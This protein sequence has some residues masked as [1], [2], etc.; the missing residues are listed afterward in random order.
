L[1]SST[2]RSRALFKAGFTLVELMVVVM[3]VSILCVLAVPSLS[4][5]GYE[6][7]AYT[8]AANV[9][10]LVREARTR[11][12]GRGA[13]ELLVMSASS[14]ANTASFTLYEAVTATGAGGADAGAT[15]PSSTCNPPTIWPGGSGTVTASFVDG[16][17]IAPTSS[18]NPTIE[19]QGNI[20][21]RVNDPNSGSS[22]GANS[23]YL[24]FT[25]AGRTWYYD[26]A[27]TPP[28]TFTQSLASAGG[29]GAIT[30]DVTI[31]AFPTSTTGATSSTNLIRTV[32]I[33]PSGNTRVTSQ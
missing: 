16:F 23:L 33:P 15:I 26:Q 6:R 18:G 24:C 3:I 1:V 30:V 20:N 11:A 13:A 10:E 31:G 7:R 9:A 25:P 29:V 28:T 2:S 14:T 27:T 22:I 17:Q 8:D 32:W 4:H 5:E 19:G 12:V 21:M